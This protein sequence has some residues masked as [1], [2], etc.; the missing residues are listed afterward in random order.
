MGHFDNPYSGAEREL[1]DI[2]K[3]LAGRRP[4]QFWSDIAPHRFYAERGARALAPYAGEFPKDGVLLVAGVHVLLG[5][6]LKY[7]RF[8]R[9][10]MLYN[11]ANHE[12]LFATLAAL[13]SLVACEVD[14][15]FVSRMLQLSVSLPGRVIHSVIDL[16]PYLA[17][18]PMVPQSSSGPD[19]AAPGRPF[20]IGRVSRDEV[21][22][23]H[24][25]DPSLYRML[26]ANGV[27]VRVMGG[28]CLARELEGVDGVELLAA[29]AESVPVFLKS[30]DV[31]FYRTGTWVEAYG[32]VVVEAMASGL[33]VVAGRVG[34][35]EDLVRQGASGYLVNTQEEAF[36][37]LMALVGQPVM[38]S[39]LGK[40]ARIDALSR[41]GQ[42]AS[43]AVIQSW[44]L[45]S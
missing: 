33:P 4:V 31:F 10:I 35:Y 41:H 29:G 30:L 27:R 34:G 11:L 14:L 43:E 17:Q 15:V 32:R 19:G 37:A 25:Q 7:A 28:C 5:N 24:P 26:A 6:W 1:L 13:R 40:A 45:T 16:E 20:T 22:K 42:P 3:L 9:V 38:A 21:S 12:R 39:R 44:L 36:E 18:E 8:E 2:Q 23:H